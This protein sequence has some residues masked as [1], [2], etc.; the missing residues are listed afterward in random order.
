MNLQEISKASKVLERQRK[1]L[2]NRQGIRTILKGVMPPSRD[3]P[4]T[5][6][7]IQCMKMYCSSV[8]NFTNTSLRKTC[9][10]LEYLKF[11][12]L[13]DFKRFWASLK[14][15]TLI[16]PSLVPLCY[17]ILRNGWD[18][19]WHLLYKKSLDLCSD[20]GEM[21]NYTVSVNSEK[22][23]IIREITRQLLLVDPKIWIPTTVLP[24][25]EY[26]REG[27]M[28]YSFLDKEKY[29]SK[30]EDFRLLVQEYL[31]NLNINELFV[32]P[33]DLVLKVG[34]SRYNDGGIVRKDYERPQVSFESGFLY[35]Q[36]NPR[37]LGTREVWLPDKS[38]KINN[39][40]WMIIGRQILKKDPTYPCEDPEETYK[41]IKESLYKPFSSFDMP[42]FG[43]QYIREWL[44]IVAE[45]IVR[46]FPNPDMFENF[47][48]FKKLFNKVK[49]QMPNG[50]FVY[51][52]RGVGLGYY[53]DLKTIGVNAILARFNPISVYGDQGI[54]PK[55]AI[56]PA[57]KELRAY[58]F[59]LPVDKVVLNQ[60]EIKWGGWTMSYDRCERPKLIL[61]PLVS[62][63]TMRYH[64]ERK[65]VLESF[66]AEFPD[67]YK[68]KS[69][70]IPFQYECFF[71]FE[72]TQGD[73]LWNFR[74]SGVS[75]TSPVQTGHLKTWAVQRLKSPGDNI[76]DSFLY[77]TPFYTEW[78]EADSK[79]FSIKRKSLY[80]SSLPSQTAVFDYAH[81]IIEL[82]KNRKPELPRIAS[83]ISDYTEMKLVVNHQMTTG[84]FLF[85]L[86][87]NGAQ[88]ALSLCSRARN[89]YEAYAT[90]G[91]KVSTL[92]RGN[93]LVSYEHKFL[94]EHMLS[95][96]SELNKYI[97]TRFDS[98][99]FNYA[100]LFP[101]SR[102]NKRALDD[103]PRNM[104]S[105]SN[106][107][108]KKRIKSSYRKVSIIDMVDAN[109][110]ESVIPD[111]SGL[112]Q[113]S[114]LIGDLSSRV[115]TV[116]D[117]SDEE[118]PDADVLLFL[119]EYA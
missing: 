45:E 13:D 118:D 26:V 97:V 112:R 106:N 38:T 92:W 82:N 43:F 67:Y 8:R 68:E 27:K 53:E 72:F 37:P 64:W 69:S 83:L 33:P 15:I 9:S 100:R 6:E 50:E 84:K 2:R 1:S 116:E 114:D 79:A 49:V 115:T 46:L 11:K 14:F 71:G 58:G 62:I 7:N 73:S 101:H 31:R 78:K 22:S 41:N 59:D 96:V 76:Q 66:A 94:L 109:E 57:V 111:T 55:N 48:L 91:Y 102:P 36:F 30:S 105:T 85:G 25:Y 52:P 28:H 51:P 40:F 4:H 24:R 65:Q 95:N 56:I 77:E 80:R 75:S 3:I 23:R 74:N 81:P 113:V 35:Q 20:F 42:G 5:S 119:E 87:G 16:E 34:S 61:E 29:L 90:G 17:M 47:E 39:S 93:P 108:E 107:A 60:T 86:S 88:K 12:F 54:I 70:I 21:E 110:K 104:C 103:V 63:F 89:P 18:Q 19:E 44:F 32:P 98:R 10:R 117:S 99:N